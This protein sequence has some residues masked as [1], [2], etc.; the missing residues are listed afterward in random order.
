M[1]GT[2]SSSAG[3]STSSS[4]W[5]SGSFGGNAWSASSD[6]ANT[7]RSATD[8]RGRDDPPDAPSASFGPA[9]GPP[10]NDWAASASSHDPGW[11]DPTTGQPIA[12]A[13][14]DKATAEADVWGDSVSKAK[15]PPAVPTPQWNISTPRS[16]QQSPQRERTGTTST[17]TRATDTV[18][19]AGASLVNRVARPL[20]TAT[21][22]TTTTT[23]ASEDAS[24]I[25]LANDMRKEEMRMLSYGVPAPTAVA[26]PSGT[27]GGTPSKPNP[28]AFPSYTPAEKMLDVVQEPLSTGAVREIN[29]AEGGGEA[30]V[31]GSSGASRA[32]SPVPQP[33]PVPTVEKPSTVFSQWE[34]YVRT[35]AKAVALKIDLYTLEE[36][37]QKQRALQRSS[38]YQSA[39]LVAVHAQ[40]EKIR[41]EHDLKL[42][43]TQKKFDELMERLVRF[44]TS[45]PSTVVDPGVPPEVEEIRNYVA[46]INEWLEKIRPTVQ[47]QEEKARVAA[48]EKR[49]EEETMQA[50]AEARA[51]AVEEA[52]S[53]VAAL[54]TRVDDLD[55]KMTDLESQFEDLRVAPLDVDNVISRLLGQVAEEL[56]ITIRMPK[57]PSLSAQSQPEEGEVPVEPPPPPKSEKELAEE[58]E[59]LERQLAECTTLLERLLEQV[60]DQKARNVPKDLVYHQLAADHAAMELRLQELRQR[61][62]DDSVVIDSNRAEIANVWA[63]LQQATDR[64]PPPQPPLASADDVYKQVLPILRPELRR[65]MV[66]AM[67]ELRRGVD[68]ALS[69]Q[70]EDLC[71]QLFAACQPAI[72]L[73]QAMKNI[74]DRQPE[75]LMPPPPP[76]AQSVQ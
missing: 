17:T 68:E 3:P 5:G 76:P 69:K 62:Q 7:G 22:S 61:Q 55:E 43:R 41:G 28:F 4:G 21:T 59:R 1:P 31:L 75:M 33:L 73:I 26:G 16:P 60:H 27:S 2:A 54:T 44:P 12:P 52:R 45:G 32:N 66:E 36:A 24:A 72:R 11:G 70:E 20:A 14:N 51:A 47:E 37:R 6:H 15:E 40:I 19:R 56:G 64:E 53:Q 39:S 9:W 71:A 18:R 50:E 35:L 23:T 30:S 8:S 58:C 48:Q 34:N 13:I 57:E 38:Q 49:E 25:A 29:M 42:R 74:S 67:N 46:G 10:S 65:S 63:L